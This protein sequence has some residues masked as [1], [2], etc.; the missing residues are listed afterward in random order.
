M[1]SKCVPLSIFFCI[2]FKFL[3][4]SACFGKNFCTRLPVLIKHS[5]S[6][7]LGKI[8]YLVFSIFL[9]SYPTESEFSSK[10][11]LIPGLVSV[12]SELCEPPG[13]GVLIGLGG[14][15]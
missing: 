13:I 15:L 1:A 10:S 5:N 3:L 9:K 14:S 4:I 11:V 12:L 6:E 8:I 2:T 7:V